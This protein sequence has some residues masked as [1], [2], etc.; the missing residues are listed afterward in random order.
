VR[1]NCLWAG[2]SRQ[3]DS[4]DRPHAAPRCSVRCYADARLHQV[5]LLVDEPSREHLD[6]VRRCAGPDPEH[7]LAT[8]SSLDGE[9]ER[10]RA[11]EREV[12]LRDQ[13]LQAGGDGR[14]SACR[15]AP[16]CRC[17]ARTCASSKATRSAG[18]SPGDRR[19]GSAVS[20]SAVT[21]AIC[22]L[23]SCRRR[24]R[25]CRPPTPRFAPKRCTPRPAAP[26]CCGR[27]SGSSSNRRRRSSRPSRRRWRA[28][29]CSSG[30]SPTSAPPW[31]RL[32]VAGHPHAADELVVLAPG[33]EPMAGA[34]FVRGRVRHPDHATVG[35]RS[36]RRAVRNAEPTVDGGARM[37]GVTWVD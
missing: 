34:V 15:R 33:A 16:P 23:P 31:R 13:D 28:A 5:V 32:R 24:A 3:E 6:A 26:A 37:P 22:S 20:S 30:G 12:R 29:R 8:S 10:A 17:P 27:A 19:A 2:R 1:V 4:D 21:S 35:F 7:G 14:R 9:M 11:V 18:S 36:W 25:R